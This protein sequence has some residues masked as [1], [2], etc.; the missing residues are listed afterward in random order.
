MYAITVIILSEALFSS[1]FSRQIEAGWGARSNCS[2]PVTF[3]GL[4]SAKLTSNRPSPGN[5]RPRND[6]PGP[7]ASWA[8][9]PAVKNTTGNPNVLLFYN[10]PYLET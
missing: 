3:D 9:E 10:R 5:F 1:A 2:L 4:T 6:T 7:E 8:A